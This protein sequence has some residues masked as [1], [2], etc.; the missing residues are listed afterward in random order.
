MAVNSD[1]YFSNAIQ[2]IPGIGSDQS[3]YRV[4]TVPAFALGHLLETQDGR[5]FRYAHIGAAEKQG[6]LVSQDISES[7]LALNN[8]TVVAPASSAV[9]TDG[10]V[11]QKFIEGTDASR[12]LDDIAGGHLVTTAGTG[13][14]YTYR[15]KTNTATGLPGGPASGNFRIELH[16]N[17]QASLTADTDVTVVGCKY[18]NLESSTGATDVIPAGVIQGTQD[19]ADRWGWI[20]TRGL[21]GVLQ[22]GTV[23]QGDIVTVSDVDAGAVMQIGGFSRSVGGSQSVSDLVNEPIVGWCAMNSTDT[24][25]GVYVTINLTLE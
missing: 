12:I 9:T 23:L 21:C 2:G 6:A 22:D 16:D 13:R 8:V 5:R 3:L 10:T 11:N 24:A 18:A 20:Q 25:D 1:N 19:T 17:L 4:D 7:S 15:I 14:G